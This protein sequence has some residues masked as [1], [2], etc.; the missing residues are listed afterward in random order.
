[1][2]FPCV[3]PVYPHPVPSN[4]SQWGWNVLKVCPIIS[5]GKFLIQ[6]YAAAGMFVNNWGFPWCPCA[7]GFLMSGSWR[8]SLLW[9]MELFLE[10]VLVAVCKR[11]WRKSSF[12]VFCRKY[13]ECGRSKKEVHEFWEDWTGVSICCFSVL[14]LSFPYAKKNSPKPG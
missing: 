6:G 7:S 11:T 14:N 12:F 10:L 9:S 13:C 3:R 4:N 5:E 1:M 2:V 8:Q